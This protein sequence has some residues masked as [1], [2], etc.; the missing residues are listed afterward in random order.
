M[1]ITDEI[2]AEL[3]RLEE[4]LLNPEV[5]RSR[6][7][8]DALLADDFLEYGASGRT[9]DKSALLSMTDKAY[10][11]ELL[12]HAFSAMALAPSVALVRYRS[13]LRRAD[14]RES[15][16]LRCSVWSL[17]EKGWQLVFHQGTPTVPEIP[18]D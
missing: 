17:T 5:R 10:D 12:L 16:A 7:R 6:A 15:H 3:Q 9:Y 13:L 8:L 2:A 11:G 1:Q 4:T 18:Q 14:G